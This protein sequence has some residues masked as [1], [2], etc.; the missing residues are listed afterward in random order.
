MSRYTTFAGSLIKTA[1]VLG[2]IALAAPALADPAIYVFP[3]VH[4]DGGGNE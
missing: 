2:S 3:G 1:A 4:D